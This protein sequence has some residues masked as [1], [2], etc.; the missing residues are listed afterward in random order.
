[1]RIIPWGK[2]SK[3]TISVID[4][5]RVKISVCLSVCLSVVFVNVEYDQP[6]YHTK[7]SGM[8]KLRSPYTDLNF[9]MLCCGQ[10][11]INTQIHLK[12]HPAPTVYKPTEIAI[13][14]HSN[15]SGQI[16]SP[17]VTNRDNEQ[18]LCPQ[19][20]NRSKLVKNCLTSAW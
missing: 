16:L 8:T 18:R 6:S 7:N 20:S 19:R 2:L 3:L 17:Q 5:K 12:S 9:A 1:M 14:G 10:T 11:T 15:N 4:D 13:Y